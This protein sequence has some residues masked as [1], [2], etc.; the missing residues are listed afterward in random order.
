MAGRTAEERR[1]LPHCSDAEDT[2]A[3]GEG[4]GCC[5]K[6]AEWWHGHRGH[7]RGQ[8]ED[9]HHIGSPSGA[10]PVQRCRRDAMTAGSPLRAQ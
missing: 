1:E 3:H 2:A 10:V 7:D 6:V 9:I 8:E 5:E 4:P